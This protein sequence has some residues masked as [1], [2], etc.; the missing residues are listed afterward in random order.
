[1][2][3]VGGLLSGSKG[4][5]FSATGANPAQM[6]TA[7]Q[8]TQDSIKQQ[9]DFVNALQAQNGLN[10]QSNVFQQQ[11]NLANQYQNV[12]NGQGPNPAQAML[13]QATGQNVAAQ[14]ALMAGQRG[15]SANTG[16]IARQAAQQG[17]NTQQQAVGQ[18][19]SMQAQQQLAALAQLQQ[20]QANMGNLANAQVNQQQAGNANL[21]Q[22]ALGQQSNVYG[23]Q[24]NANSTNAA[25]A[26][27]NA[28]SQSNLLGNLAGAAGTAFG[29]MAGGPPGAAAGSSL[30][31]SL[32]A[33]MSAYASGG[34]VSKG[35]KSYASKHILKMAEGGKVPVL[36]SP[37]EIKLDPNQAQA[38][39][40]GANPMAEGKKVPGKAIVGGAKNS[41]T[42]DTVKDSVD[43]G[44]III[45]RSV[46]QGKNPDKKA[47]EFVKAV[48]ARKGKK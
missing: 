44:S 3:F 2:S 15:A 31:T 36:L 39:K 42:N 22:Q 10:N 35:P 34:E 18:G 26:E 37:G 13:N 21:G 29:F 1:M 6:K 5:G 25:V 12:A 45:P 7:F 17:A 20:Q 43:E 47:A 8:N 11:Q 19:A 40:A 9:K 14:N 46:T 16:L 30:G 24:Q 48:L 4:A 41:Y 33:K 28:K 32:G 27:Q 38:V 23:L